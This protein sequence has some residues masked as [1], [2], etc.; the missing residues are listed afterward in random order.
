M[1]EKMGKKEDSRSM[2][3]K[4]EKEPLRGTEEF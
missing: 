1:M 2:H 3:F 4:M